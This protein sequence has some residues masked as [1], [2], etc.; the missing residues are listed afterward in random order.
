MVSVACC[1]ACRGDGAG[2]ICGRPRNWRG[3]GQA[4]AAEIT[5]PSLNRR[6]LSSTSDLGSGRI[7][8]TTESGM[9]AHLMAAWQ[10]W[11]FGTRREQGMEVMCPHHHPTCSF[12]G[13]LAASLAIFHA[14]CGKC[15]AAF[16]RERGAEMDKMGR[17]HQSRFSC[18]PKRKLPRGSAVSDQP[19]PPRHPGHDTQRSV[20]RSGQIRQS[21]WY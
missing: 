7:V 1:C 17:F 4:G 2:C 13:D 3:I 6:V 12:A 15:S 20:G 14:S 18:A 21:R 9:N 16:D 11:R 5:T 8:A 19:A 10:P